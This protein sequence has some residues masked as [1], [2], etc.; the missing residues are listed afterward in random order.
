MMSWGKVKVM[1]KGHVIKALLCPTAMSICH[2]C[3]TVSVCDCRY[4]GRL[5]TRDAFIGPAAVDLRHD[6]KGTA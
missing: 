3:I 4:C 1:L 5:G 2:F 6:N